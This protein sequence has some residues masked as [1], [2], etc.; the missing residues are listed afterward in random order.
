MNEEGKVVS[1]GL[2]F[3][4]AHTVTGCPGSGS[5]VLRNGCRQQGSPEIGH[6]GTGILMM[7][8]ML[9]STATDRYTASPICWIPCCRSQELCCGPRPS[10]QASL[11]RAVQTLH[12]WLLWAMSFL[13]RPAVAVP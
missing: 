3:T 10:S 12:W 7:C 11:A 13:V 8:H 9:P 1:G 6:Q 4:A 2:L 5:W